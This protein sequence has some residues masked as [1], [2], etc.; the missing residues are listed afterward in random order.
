ML[1]PFKEEIHAA[2]N[3]FKGILSQ[4][5]KLMIDIKP[6]LKVLSKVK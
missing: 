1:M 2:Q 6:L 4:H 3:E 5:N